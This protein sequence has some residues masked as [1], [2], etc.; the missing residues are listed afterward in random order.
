MP[1]TNDT[2][3]TTSYDNDAKGSSSFS[4]DIKPSSLTS[5]FLLLENG[6]YLLKEDGYKIVLT[7]GGSIYTNDTK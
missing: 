3:P 6:S 1:Y 4:N 5:F 7:S 2:K